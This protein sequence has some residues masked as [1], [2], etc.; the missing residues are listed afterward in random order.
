MG[1]HVIK[2]PDIGEGIAEAEIVAWHVKIGD[3]IEEDQP[4]ADMMTD[5]ATVEVP[6]PVTG[7][8]TGL[9]AEVGATIAVE[10]G[11]GQRAAG[12]LSAVGGAPFRL[13]APAD[14][15]ARRPAGGRAGACG[16]DL[17]RCI[18]GDRPAFAPVAAALTPQ[19][20]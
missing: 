1:T 19:G 8:V 5:K 16:A 13:A 15:A 6:S 18:G 12:R 14:L 4:L 11:G 17:L 9:G 3:W 2:M 20:S 7:K 10:V